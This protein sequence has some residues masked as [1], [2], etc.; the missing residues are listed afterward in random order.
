MEEAKKEEQLYQEWQM[1]LQ[2][3]HQRQVLAITVFEN[4]LKK[5]E[6]NDITLQALIGVYCVGTPKLQQDVKKI[7]L[8][9]PDC[10]RNRRQVILE[11]FDIID[12]TLAEIRN[13]YSK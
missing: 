2:L 1:E 12:A 3:Y 9:L 5:T 10:F 6:E 4:I 13:R 8:D 11:A 7:V